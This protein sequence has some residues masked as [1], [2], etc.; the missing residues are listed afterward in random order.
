MKTILV[1]CAI[2]ALW[3]GAVVAQDTD[4]ERC[5]ELPA[6]VAKTRD[7]IKAAA[8]AGD[9]KALGKIAD[10]NRFT[11]SFGADSG[12]PTAF[13]ESLKT[14]G[15]DV[16]ATISA[17]LD[18]GCVYFDIEGDTTYYEWPTASEIAYQYLTAE[19]ID[20]L[21]ALYGDVE[22]QYVE[23]TAVGYYVGWR[24]LIAKDG[25]WDSFVAGD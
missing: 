14:E 15:T 4:F 21:K 9:L 11:Y 23:G 18:M 1:T 22:T 7:A 6:P 25:R 17:L 2:A 8:D 20:A 24:L 16:A 5:N 12:D 13:W 10:P 19:E 3:S